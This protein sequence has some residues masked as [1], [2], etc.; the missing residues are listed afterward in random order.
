MAA[1]AAAPN[2]NGDGIC[3]SKAAAAKGSLSPGNKW[4]APAAKEAPPATEAAAA[5]AAVE[6]IE[7]EGAGGGEVTDEGVFDA[8]GV[9]IELTLKSEDG[10]G[11]VSTVGVDVLPVVDV[12]DVV[13]FAGTW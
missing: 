3:C 5:A 1:A 10:F 8:D 13:A 9:R 11:E 7:S 12:S 6:V 4:P 2:P